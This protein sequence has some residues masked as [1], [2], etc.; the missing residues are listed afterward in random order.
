MNKFK[1]IK[2]P[3]VLG[4]ID[5]YDFIDRIKN[6]HPKV[7]KMINDARL[8][9]STNKLEYDSIKEQLPCFTLNFDF[10]NKKLNSNIKYPTGFIYID[11]DDTTEIDLSNKHIFA[12]WLSLSGK[13]RGVLVK[14]DGLTLDNFKNTYYEVSQLLSVKSDFRADKATQFC[15]HSYD[16]NIYINT[17]S[18]TYQSKEVIKK[19]PNTVL[20]IKKGRRVNTEM[21][22]NNKLRFNNISDYDFDDE[23]YIV[24]WKAKEP[25]SQVYVPHLIL[26]GKRESTLSTIAYQ[27]KALNIEMTKNELL[28]FLSSINQ[29]KCIPPLPN[30]EIEKIANHKMSLLEIAPILNKD[31]R[32]IFNPESK[33]SRSEKTVIINQTLGVLKEE[34]SRTKIRECIDSWDYESLGNITQVKLAIETGLNIKTVE[35]YYKEFKLLVRKSNK[36]FCAHC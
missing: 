8:L 7:L 36:L 10:N 2:S 1:N 9:H 23:D 24:F 17:D 20:N 21:G 34:K 18:K 25:I 16:T 31:R 26:E 6:P 11:V 5:V 13:G 12:T 15:V 22:V 32:I 28:H 30:T 35:K 29:K 4:E 27:C 14:V 33:L 3:T 19:S